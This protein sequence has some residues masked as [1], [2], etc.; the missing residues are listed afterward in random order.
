M[1]ENLRFIEKLR[2][3]VTV[4]HVGVFDEFMQNT[5]RNGHSF[6]QKYTN[7]ATYYIANTNKVWIRSTIIVMLPL[8]GE[9]GLVVTSRMK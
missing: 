4:E 2:T 6:T 7:T 1:N 3:D 8:E 9:E 5:G